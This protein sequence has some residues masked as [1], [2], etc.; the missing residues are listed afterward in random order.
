MGVLGSGS[1]RTVDRMDDLRDDGVVPGARIAAHRL[2]R[3]PLMLVLALSVGLGVVGCS[4]GEGQGPSEPPSSSEPDVLAGWSLEEKVGQLLMVGVDVAQPQQ[5]AFDAVEQHLVGNIFIGGRTTAG[6][7]GV[8]TLVDSLTGLEPK[9]GVAMFVATD[10]EGGL[11][12]VMRGPGFSDI[13]SALDQANLPPRSLEKRAAQWGREL[14][15]GGVNLNLAPV[16][17]VVASAKAAKSNPP[18]GFFERNYGFDPEELVLHANAFSTG[19]ESAG[20]DVAIKHFPGLGRV[21]GNTDDTAGV[22]DRVVGPDAPELEVFGAGIEAGAAFVMMSS[23][24]YDELDPDVPALFSQR[25][26]TGLLRDELGF[27][28]VV[29]TDDVGAAEQVQ[30]WSPA[31]R[32]VKFVEAGGDMILV[33]HRSEII[34]EMTNALIS[35]A[36]EDPD[37]ES[38]VDEAVLRILAAKP[39]QL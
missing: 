24:I 12:Q 32:A 35:R 22:T 31:Q 11:V 29:I 33:A 4:G 30:K 10:Q 39:S 13:P 5:G 18:I 23:A 8:R 15:D 37:F 1:D 16:M 26:V 3:L 28:G 21:A 38:M 19:M 36:Q 25:I 2:R 6:T 9:D 34:A 7:K 14:A 17:D 27:D 20:V